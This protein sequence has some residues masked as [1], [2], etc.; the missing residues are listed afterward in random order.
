MSIA[1]GTTGTGLDRIVEI[2][3]ADP[4]LRASIPQSQ[5][6]GGAQAADGLNQ[7]IADGLAAVGDLSDGHINVSDVV[8]VQQWIRADAGRYRHFVELHGDDENGTET[9]YHLVQNDGGTTTMFWGQ[10]FVDTIADGLY[11]IGFEIRNGR[12]LNEDGNANARV[13]HVSHWLGYFWFGR[14]F[15]EGTARA[16]TLAGYEVDD[17]IQGGGGNDHIWSGE[18]NDILDGGTGNDT[19]AG[20]AGDDRLLGGAGNDRLWAGDG[21]DVVIGGDGNDQSAGDGGND[22]MDGGAGNDQLWAG[23]GDDTVVGGDGNDVLTGDAGDDLL[24]GGAGNDQLWAG[25]GD[26]TIRGGDGNDQSSGDAGDDDM[27]GDPGDDR[28]W[29][30]DGDDIVVGGNGNDLITG[31]GGRDTLDGGAGSDRIYGGADSDVV[32]GGAGDDHLWGGA[33]ADRF[34]VGQAD[35]FDRIYDFDPDDGDVLAITLDDVLDQSVAAIDRITA[36]KRGSHLDIGVD[37]DM[38]GSADIE[39]VRLQWHGWTDFD[40]LVDNGAVVATYG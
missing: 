18:G 38:N 36:E 37:L 10:N 8:A 19:L 16:D 13:D 26:D 30:G 15:I 22:T 29:A 1:G 24:D 32:R 14:T 3:L 20:D 17:E 5:I 9:G 2:I 12:F 31:D 39:L 40:Q 6:E 7:L 4:G 11:H 23:D 25:D 27:A 21:D 35:G 28:L 34:E 33:D